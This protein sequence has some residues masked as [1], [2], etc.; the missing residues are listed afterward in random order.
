MTADHL[1]NI[2]QFGFFRTF[3]EAD[4]EISAAC[5]WRFLKVVL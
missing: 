2:E 5:H 1:N 4:G 3:G